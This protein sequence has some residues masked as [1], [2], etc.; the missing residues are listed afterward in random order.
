MARKALAYYLQ[1]L[2]HDLPAG[3]VVFLVALP[4]C[5]GIALASGA[6]L[7]SGLVSGIVGG[8]V[9]SL[10]SGSQ[11]SVSGP[12]AGLTVIVLHG[13]DRVGGFE[14]FLV[15][16]VLA[17]ILQWLLGTV[18]AGVIGAYFPS[19]VIRGMLTAI[20]LILIM[21]QLPH[22]V[23]FDLDALVDETY[24]PQTPSSTFLEIGDALRAIS[25]GATLV[26]AVS[27]LIMMLWESPFLRKLGLLSWLPGPLVAVIWGVAFEISAMGGAWEIRGQHLV[28]L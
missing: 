19:A 20:G 16:V 12:A 24:S 4:L 5:L 15:A 18:K 8:L 17:G 7:F 10:L 23:G 28:S 9:V 14:A 26:S 27:L 13:I 1:N 22:A 25:P 2:R 3:L 6:P 11:L 21:K